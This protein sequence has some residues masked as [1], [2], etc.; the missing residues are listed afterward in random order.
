MK[1]ERPSRS[2][3]GTAKHRKM[4]D[5]LELFRVVFKSV[6]RHY[7]VVERSTGI[8]GAQLWTLAQIA[9]KPGIRVGD[10]ARA[11]AVHQSTASNLLRD[12]DAAA[13]IT[14]KRMREDRRTVRLHATTRGLEVLKR[15]PR[16]LIGVLQHALL[17]LPGANLNALH[18]QLNRVI[19]AMQA[20]DRAARGTPLSE[21]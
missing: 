13:L 10:L 20:T 5:V 3:G 2:A 11:L 19:D 4:L 8:R 16:P 9:E 6:R 7:Q 21:L 15:A 12:L 1:L 14:R 17:D 18:R